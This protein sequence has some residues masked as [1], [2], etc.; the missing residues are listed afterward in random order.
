M[1]NI[2]KNKDGGGDAS[3][4][5]AEVADFENE[6]QAAA[7]DL[8]ALEGA[9]GMRV[10]PTEASVTQALEDA[11]DHGSAK[12][13]ARAV[14]DAA[15]FEWGHEEKRHMAETALMRHVAGLCQAAG[16]AKP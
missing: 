1:D 10:V 2:D 13:K 15:K 6:M 14:I 16:Y 8:D 11:F 3:V 12:D 9:D 4:E 5:A 7:S